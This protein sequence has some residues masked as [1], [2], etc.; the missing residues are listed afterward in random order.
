MVVKHF[1]DRPAPAAALRSFLSSPDGLSFALCSPNLHQSLPLRMSSL[2]RQ[3]ASVASLDAD[4]LGASAKA[5]SAQP[6]YLFTPT[7]AAQHDL[8]TIHALG[9]NGFEELVDIDPSLAAYEDELFSEASK[10][11]D[12]M[13]LP[14]D[15]NETLGLELDAFLWRLGR[16]IPTRA[17][18][19][20][21]EWLVR[22]FR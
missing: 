18:A 15:E 22:R 1:L 6:S 19:K 20:V 11:K 13:V 14:K 10:R 12:R 8:E 17:A 16:H 2:A 9:L 5:S 4:R 3:L 21:I 7:E